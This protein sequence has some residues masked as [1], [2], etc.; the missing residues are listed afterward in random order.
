MYIKKKYFCLY[1]EHE[2]TTCDYLCLI[3]YFV[4]QQ[5]LLIAKFFENRILRMRVVFVDGTRLVSVT[6]PRHQLG[7][8]TNSFRNRTS[9]TPPPPTG[10][11][12]GHVGGRAVVSH[13][14]ASS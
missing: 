6:S 4:N 13:R 14:R 7:K 10:G 9:P 5:N 2:T 1:N 11:P 12:G 8:Y 3:S